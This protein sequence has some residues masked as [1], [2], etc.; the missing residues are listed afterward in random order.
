M[1]TIMLYDIAESKWYN[2][3]A[4]GSIPEMRRRFCAGV[5]WAQDRSSYNIYIYGGAGFYDDING[6]DDVYI[7][8][9]PAFKWIKWYPTEPGRGHPHGSLSCNVVDGAQ[10]LIIGGLFTETQECDAPEV[11]GTHNLD[12]GK[13][14]T[15][16]SKW[17]LFQPN[18]TTY[19]VPSEIIA[20]VG[21]RYAVF[22]L[23]FLPISL[24]ESF[25]TVPLEARRTDHP[26]KDGNIATSPCTSHK[27]PHTPRAP[28]PARYL[29]RQ[30]L[31]HLITITTTL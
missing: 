23:H 30:T 27:K 25:Y 28:Q 2:Q 1:D 29:R 4:T 17:N 24:T 8:T 3:T 20:V 26:K 11:W 31:R 10:M 6:F 13:S 9:M 7:L 16:E 5:T 22:N 19:N 18:L 21:G 14:N 12:L 15:Q